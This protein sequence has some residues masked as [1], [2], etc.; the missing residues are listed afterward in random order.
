M[1]LPYT[2]QGPFN[3]FATMLA[4]TADLD[5]TW[6]FLNVGVIKKRVIKYR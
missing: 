4:K 2:L 6:P 1:S 5:K 3:A